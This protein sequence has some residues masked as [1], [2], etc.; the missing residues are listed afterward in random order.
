MER[1][2][3]FERDDFAVSPA[4]ED[5]VR[6]VD[7]WPEWP[8]GRLALVGPS[9]SG[10]THLARAWAEKAGAVVIDAADPNLAPLDLPAL[11]GRAI[12]IEDADRRALGGV[13]SDEDLFHLLNMAGIDGGSLLLTAQVAPL[14][15]RTVVPDLRSRLNALTAAVIDEP[16]DV[17]LEAVLRRAFAD[18]LI[19]P[20]DDVYAFL[21]RRIPRSAPEAV[22]LVA[23]LD[24]AASESGR[25]ITRAFAA[26][27]LAFG[28]DEDFD[29][30]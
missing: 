12:L 11:R 25:G 23:L 1:P 10:K 16:D 2:P 29:E 20:A 19:R 28:E 4:N 24:E 18:R 9:G 6:A 14:E 27:V 7:T 3:S 5:A 30:A 26:Q 13:V 8:N 17:V 15:W 21:L 22:A